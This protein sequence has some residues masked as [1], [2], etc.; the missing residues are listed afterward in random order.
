MILSYKHNHKAQY[1]PD[2]GIAEMVHFATHHRRGRWWDHGRWTRRGYHFRAAVHR[3]LLRG[4]ERR[5]VVVVVVVRVRM[6][7]VMVQSIRVVSLS[8][9]LLGRYAR[10]VVVLRWW[11]W[12]WRLL[13][14]LLLLLWLLVHIQEQVLSRATET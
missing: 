6:M 5:L 9:L 7:V 1:I 13:L 2:S 8:M 10:W 3:G 14:L 12:R 4:G 11:W